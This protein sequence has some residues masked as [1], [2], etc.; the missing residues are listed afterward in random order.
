MERKDDFF[1][2]NDDKSAERLKSLKNKYVV[3]EI[4]GSNGLQTIPGKLLDVFHTMVYVKEYDDG[5]K[6]SKGESS[7]GNDNLE[8]IKISSI[9][10][11]EEIKNKNDLSSRYLNQNCEI[12]NVYGKKINAYVSG[13]D[14]FNLE[15]E[16]D[17]VTSLYPY[18]LVQS[19]CMIK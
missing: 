19:I 14:G 4:E 10:G 8:D 6:K 18:C 7:F 1:L 16:V 15:C 13:Y 2:I 17:N 9:R 5:K 11:I 12:T 3:L